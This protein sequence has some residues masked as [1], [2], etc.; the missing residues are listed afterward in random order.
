MNIVAILVQIAVSLLVVA[1]YHLWVSRKKQ[2]VPA[3]SAP[4][5]SVV[6]APVAAPPKT[7]PGPPMEP[8]PPEIIAVI[9]AAIA[10]VI[11]RPHRVVSVQQD[12]A[13]TPEISVWAL[14]GRVEQFMSHRVR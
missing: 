11:G 12:L 7:S 8:V 2:P 9:A 13:N 6:V 5:A 1:L 14:E 10:V 4:V 3:P